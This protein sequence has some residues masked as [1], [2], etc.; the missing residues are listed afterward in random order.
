MDKI[1]IEV[2]ICDKDTYELELWDY[3]DSVDD[4]AAQLDNL[5]AYIKEE[6]EYEI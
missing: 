6:Y 1:L 3:Y 5:R 4:L 2:T